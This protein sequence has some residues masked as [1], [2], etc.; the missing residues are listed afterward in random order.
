MKFFITSPWRNREAVERLTNELE[1]QG[2]AVQSF[3][4]SGANLLTGKP[5]EEEMNEFSEALVNWKE[6]DRI[7]KIVSSEVEAIKACDA[8]ILLLPGGISSHMEAGIGYGL[9]KRLILIGPI[10]KP[11]VLYLLFNH[12]YIDTSSF[13]KDF[14]SVPK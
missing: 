8:V 4:N 12:V 5:I 7:A 2:H 14:A 1:E 10:A 6:N 9:G 11:E 13:L 3:L